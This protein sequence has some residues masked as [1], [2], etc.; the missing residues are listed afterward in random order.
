MQ[1]GKEL[2][3]Y[4]CNLHNPDPDV[5][6]VKKGLDVTIVQPGELTEP[7]EPG[8]GEGPMIPDDPDEPY[9]IDPNAPDAS[10]GQEEEGNN[11]ATGN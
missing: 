7:E 10:A 3:H 2:P 5:Y 1:I 9:P 11:A 4:Y 8:E 6:K